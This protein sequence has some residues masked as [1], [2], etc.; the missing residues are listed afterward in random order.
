MFHRIPRECAPFCGPLFPVFTKIDPRLVAINCVGKGGDQY[1][2]ISCFRA[3][4]RADEKGDGFPIIAAG[5]A[6]GLGPAAQPFRHRETEIGLP[7]AVRDVVL[8][9]M[10]RAIGFRRV[11]PVAFLAAPVRASHGAGWCVNK[12]AVQTIGTG[13]GNTK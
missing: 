1:A 4:W 8:V 13:I 11:A 3:L 10:D 2:E 9:K 12:C 6:G 7:A 5:A